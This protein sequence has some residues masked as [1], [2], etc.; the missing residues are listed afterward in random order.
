MKRRD[1]IKSTF[2]LSAIGSCLPTYLLGSNGRF[3][4]RNSNIISDKIVIFVKMNGGNDGLN[5]LIPHQNVSYYD[6]RPSIAIS[7]EELHPITD[8]L[9]FHP[10]LNNWQELF[11]A[12]K[13]AIIQG[14][15]YQ[16]GNLSHFRS[17]DI[18]DTGSNED[19][20]LTTGWLGRLLET[21][22][23]DF[24]NNSPEHPLAIQ[25]NSANLLEFKTTDSNT[26]LYIYDPE[27]MES[28]ITGNYI[29]NINQNIPDTYGGDELAFIKE[30]DYMA[31]NYCQILS[32]SAQNAP[33]TIF[34]YPT[35]NI[36]DQFKITSKLITGGLSTPFYRLYQ[37][38]YDTHIDQLSR[39]E[40]LLSELSSAL[41]VF[42]NEMETLGL[43]DRILII[44][45]SEFGR[46]VYENGSGGTDHGTSAPLFI[47]GS[48]INS[49]IYGVD[50]DFNQLDENDNPLVQ[51][52]YRQIYTSIITDWFGLNQSVANQI[53]SENFNR[54]SFV[55]TNMSSGNYIKPRRI[56]IQAPY[57]NPFNNSITLDYKLFK[58][59]NVE[60]VIFDIKGNLVKNL[61][62]GNQIS[63]FKS[64][65]WN[66]IN[67]K[68]KKVPAG[69][70]LAQ[71]KIGDFTQTKKMIF[72]K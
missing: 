11:N 41:N 3:N 67:N 2:A 15:G 13:M 61:F 51:F 7:G 32:D 39:H 33:N 31:F 21:E 8:T 45:T 18:W 10:A 30:L 1:F 63:G 48:K 35:T 37:N 4:F 59:S 20:E 52:D 68:G 53:F 72:V 17:S 16:N 19:I 58:D 50:P 34:S 65:K 22:Y 40:Q 28:I 62:S 12:Q 23:P 43:L 57:P 26:G 46:R 38:G 47:F 27:I 70:Y 64:I 56:E 60:I 36:G 55:N 14:V 66:A 24:P 6:L 69:E 71:I 9:G 25:Y 42:I 29:D 5:T 44:T 54:I 49:G